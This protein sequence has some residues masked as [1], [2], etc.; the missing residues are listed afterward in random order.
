LKTKLTLL[1]FI[2]SFGGI[3]G[4]CIALRF[5]E[6]SSFNFYDLSTSFQEVSTD[7]I[8]SNVRFSIG[9]GNLNAHPLLY[10]LYKKSHIQHQQVEYSAVFSLFEQIIKQAGNQG[11]PFATI[12]LDSV[13]RK[14]EIIFGQMAYQNGPYISFDSLNLIGES[15]IKKDFLS[16][17]LGITYGSSFSQMK[18]DKGLNKLRN[19]SYLRLNGPSEISFQNEKA[20]LHLPLMDRKANQLDA[21]FG[22]IP[23]PSTQGKYYVVGLL[24]LTLRNLFGRG[25][26]LSLKWQRPQLVSQTFELEAMEPQ[27]FRSNIDFYLNMSLLKQDSLFL[28]RAIDMKIGYPVGKFYFMLFSRN[29]SSNILLSEN[30]EKRSAKWMDNKFRVIGFKGNITDLDQVI[31]PKKGFKYEFE[32]GMGNKSILKNI[33]E[34]DQEILALPKNSFQYFI[35]GEFQHYKP[36]GKNIVFSTN[37]RYGILDGKRIFTNE[38]YRIGGQKTFRG[39]QENYFYTNQYMILSTEPRIYFESDSYFMIFADIGQLST[40]ISKE[41]PISSGLGLAME[42]ESGIFNLTLAQSLSTR[43]IKNTQGLMLHFGYTGRF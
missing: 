30:S 27:F 11:Y 26:G 18:I 38:F 3:K 7:S 37:L 15:K 24:D 40:S 42:T 21:F 41:I 28:N 6:D 14:N 2:L 19:L 36:L 17:Y 33:D 4:N 23:N 35:E 16:S 12:R 9:P 8:T 5:L 10:L 20:T 1:F 34:R 29:K 31:S 39:Y 43:P 13:V 32:M 25:R 22:V